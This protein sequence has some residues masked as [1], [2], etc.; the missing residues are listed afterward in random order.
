MDLTEHYQ[1]KEPTKHVYDLLVKRLIILFIYHLAL[2][3]IALSYETEQFPA[4]R[5]SQFLQGCKHIF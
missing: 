3:H 5:V 4:P 2:V 1:Q